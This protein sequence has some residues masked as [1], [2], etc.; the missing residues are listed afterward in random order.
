MVWGHIGGVS[1]VRKNLSDSRIAAG[2]FRPRWSRQIRVAGIYPLFIPANSPVLSLHVLLRL[3]RPA[4]YAT[5]REVN[6]AAFGSS[7]EAGIIERLRDAGLVIASLVAVNAAGQIVGHI[8]FSPV[9]IT[10]TGGNQ[11]QVASLAPMAVLPI[12]QRRGIGSMLVQRGI[13]L[14]RAA[15]YSAV[16]VVGHPAYY[17]RFGFSH[18][19]VA[20]LNN[21]FAAD[22]AFMGIE[23]RP[24][25]LSE[26]D[27]QV[28]YPKAF[29][30]SR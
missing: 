18:A 1:E 9:T 26:I 14:C 11:I 24:G 6:L 23:L 30:Q 8:L 22:E 28:I 5:I 25:A 7:F 3:E 2:F 29:N 12:H 21:P 15:G 16:V 20:K 4:D 19:V 17:P 27:G 13:E 10:P